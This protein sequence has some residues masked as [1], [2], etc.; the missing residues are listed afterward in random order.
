MYFPDRGCEHTLLTLYV[1]ATAEHVTAF[2]LNCNNTVVTQTFK[3]YFKT[4]YYQYKKLKNA[5]QKC[6]N[7]SK[8]AV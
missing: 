4:A 1:Y 2:N 8:V 5:H 6:H 3:Q 7:V